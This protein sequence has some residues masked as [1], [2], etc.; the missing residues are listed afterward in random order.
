M[1]QNDVA[2]AVGGQV[3]SMVVLT[4]DEQRSFVDQRETGGGLIRGV[5][6]V[7]S[8][9]VTWEQFASA[10]QNRFIPWS[11]REES[12]LRFESL[13]QD[14]LLVTEY[15]ACYCQLSRHVLAI[16]QNDTERIRR[17]VRGL[18]FSIR[19]ATRPPAP[20]GRG[21]GRVQ[22]GSTFSYVSADF[23]AKFDMICDSMTVPIRVSTPMDFDV[24]LDM[25]W[26]SPYHD[27]LDCNGKTV[28][29]AMPGVP[30]V[31]WKSVSGSYPSKLISFIRAQ[32]LVER[33]CLCY[34]AFIR[35]TSIEPPPMDSVPVVQEFLDVFPYDLPGSPPDRDIDFVIDLE[36]GTKPISI[37]PYHMALAELKELK[38]QLQDLLSKGFIRPSLNKVKVK[39][40][41]PLPRIDGL[42]DKLQRASL[43]FKT[44]LRSGYHQL[45]IRESEFPKT[46]FRTQYGPYEFL[47]MSFRLTSAP[48]AFIELMNGVFRPYLD[49]FVIVFIDDILGYSKTEEDHVRHLRIVLQRLREE[50]LSWIGWCVDAEWKVIAYASRQ[51]KSNEKNYPSHDLELAAVVFVLKL[52][53]HYLYGVQCEIFPDHQSPVNCEHQRPGGVS[54]RMP[55]PTWKWERINMDF[56]LG[57]PTTM[58]GYDSIWV[59]V[60]RMTKSAHF[61]AVR[62]K[63]TAKKLAEVYISQIVRLHGVPI[64]IISDR[65]GQSERTIQVLEDMLRTCVIYFC[66]RWDQHLPF[67]EFAYNNNYHSSIQMAPFEALYG[68]QCRSLIGLF[69]SAEMDSLDTELLRDAMEKVCMIQYRLLTAQSR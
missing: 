5:F 39:N 48:E 4:E 33:G 25:D 44:D 65:D 34:L 37:P 23:V 64:P 26:L 1:I 18:T 51:L 54:Q 36:S 49:S 11:V 69:D 2:P 8:P 28:T 31:E 58:S 15:E 43:F 12:R 45:K 3:A 24:M 68:R 40:K 55:I 42:F 57:L 67:A 47:V 21:R 46:A 30:K 32:R 38:D 14:G 56:V 60:D 22:S 7:G 29:L 52:W 53:P 17:F 61:I 62:V 66:A 41:Y 16:I 19:S 59:I 13:R 20:Q 50:K 6:P 10:F 63:Y 9:P 27:V 35:D